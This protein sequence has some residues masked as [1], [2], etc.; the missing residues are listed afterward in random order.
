MQSNCIHAIEPSSPSKLD[1]ESGYPAEQPGNAIADINEFMRATTHLDLHREP[2]QQLA[3]LI[4]STF[5]VEAV[6]I[7]DADLNKVNRA[8][9]WLADPEDEVRNIYFFE[10]EAQDSV[11]GF[12]DR[13]L[14]MGN[15]PVGA[16]LMRGELSPQI[17][18]MVACITAITFDRYH[19]F[20]N[21][22]RTES[23]RQ[24]E[25]LRTTVLD[26][27]AHAYKSPLTAIHAASTGLSEMGN[28][29]PSQADLVALINEQSL[30]LGDLTTRLLQTAR[31]DAHQLALRK[32]PVSIATVI[33][34]VL[35]ALRERL[36]EFTI[37]LYLPVDPLSPCCDRELLTALI[38]QY[39][40]NAGKYALTGS[41]IT[42]R[43]ED[44]KHQKPEG[45]SSEIV[46]SVHNTGPAIAP[47]EQEKI[48]DRYY[49]CASTASHAPGTGIGLSIARQAAQAHGGDT[50][51]TSSIDA[52]T[53]FFASFP[54]FQEDC[55]A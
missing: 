15:L 24:T 50:W 23:A 17:S 35:A 34:N 9:E 45:A 6:A 44:R 7:F 16:L 20:A 30:E 1:E 43:V 31:L 51:V 26:S 33:D 22:S 8:G 18:D 54:I 49:R 12:I 3:A 36:S 14:R 48:F 29:T 13:V 39:I 46:F 41:T 19:S 10:K 11:T 32:E 38:T 25:Q 27:L 40:D 53:T 47:F 5:A 42:I 2:G 28:L 55:N 4:L 37:A 52:G 21:V